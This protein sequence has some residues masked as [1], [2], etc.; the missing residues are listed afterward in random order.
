MQNQ[1][2]HHAPCTCVDT[3]TP[4]A[5]RCLLAILKLSR[6]CRQIPSVSIAGLLGVKPPSICRVLEILQSDGLIEKEPY[7]KVE[8]TAEGAKTALR[9]H[10]RVRRLQ[11]VL[12][13]QLGLGQEES[14]RAAMYFLTSMEERS[15]LDMIAYTDARKEEDP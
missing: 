3:L 13:R 9:L 15:Q 7:G 8:L 11:T 14:L 12:T 2:E 5:V 1:C 10:T 4:S 6:E